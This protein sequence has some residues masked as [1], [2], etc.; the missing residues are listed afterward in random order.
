MYGNNHIALGL[1][2]NGKRSVSPVP[3]RYLRLVPKPKNKLVM[4]KGGGTDPEMDTV[5]LMKKKIRKCVHQV[6]KLAK[7]LKSSSVYQ[8]VKKDWNFIFDHIQY[9]EDP[10]D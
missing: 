3:A 6:E 1:V 5:P 10:E 4:I 7:E 2:P 8:T 9:V